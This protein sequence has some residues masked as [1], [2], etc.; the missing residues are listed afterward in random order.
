VFE[1]D[2][3]HALQAGCDDF[4]P[5][6]FK[7]EQL[8]AVLGRSLGGLEWTFS[9]TSENTETVSTA[10]NATPPLAEIDTI[11]ELSRRGD[12]LGIKKRLA[13]LVDHGGYS[14]FVA[15]LQPFVATYQMNR[16]RDAL[17]KLKEEAS[18]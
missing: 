3:Q 9:E 7:E 14:A 11:L 17:L 1:D 12:I 8:L 10:R 18:P 16:I 2:R 4:L 15:D 13:A 6:P 5:K